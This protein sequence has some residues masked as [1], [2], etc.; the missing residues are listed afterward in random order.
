VK[1]FFLPAVS[2]ALVLGFATVVW[3]RGAVP[4]WG[5]VAISVGALGV[6]A[7]ILTLED[8]LPGGF[9]NP[10]GR[11]TPPYVGRLNL[12]LRIVFGLVVASAA[13]MLALGG[14]RLGEFTPRKPVF[15]A[16]AALACASP[17]IVFRRSRSVLLPL[18][19][20]FLIACV[21]LT[22]FQRS[23]P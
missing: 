6:N 23:R 10:D 1:R 12:G 9:N 17:A 5:A 4:F 13:L 2:I 16:I 22:Y 18:A 20:A 19:T 21:L 7:L 11:S 14:L 15:W 8:D 3:W